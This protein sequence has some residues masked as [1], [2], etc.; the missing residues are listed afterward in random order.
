MQY[1]A[2]D[3][4]TFSSQNLNT[5][6]KATQNFTLISKLLKKMQ[7][8]ANKKVTGKRSLPNLFV[9]FYTNNL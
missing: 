2:F 7:K 1:Y 3:L 8:F 6:V 4:K 9:L 5:G